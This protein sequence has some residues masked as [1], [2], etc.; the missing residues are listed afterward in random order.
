MPIDFLFF[1]NYNVPDVTSF[2]PKQAMIIPP[3]IIPDPSQQYYVKTLILLRHAKSSWDDDTS[4]NDFDR[5]LSWKVMKSAQN[6]GR[7]FFRQK[8]P[9]PDCIFVSPSN[10]TLPT[11]ALV[12][13]ACLPTTATRDDKNSHIIPIELTQELCKDTKISYTGFS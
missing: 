7:Y 10:R 6:L 4:P 11:L 3:W 1:L 8:V 13:Q 9:H 12:K 5:P 2:L